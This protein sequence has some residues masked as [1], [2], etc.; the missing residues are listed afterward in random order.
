VCQAGLAELILVAA[1]L[2]N[3]REQAWLSPAISAGKAVVWGTKEILG[4]V[5]ARPELGILAVTDM[6]LARALSRAI[7]C[8]GL[9]LPDVRRSDVNGSMEVR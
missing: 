9:T 5:V 6:G 2:G 3:L 1:D 7:T 4:S 8:A